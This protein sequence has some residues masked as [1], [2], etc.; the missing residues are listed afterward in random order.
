[1]A[2]NVE[3]P[4]NPFA[5]QPVEFHFPPGETFKHFEMKWIDFR[6]MSGV[7]VTDP[8]I[9]RRLQEMT[10]RLF[11]GLKGTGYG[12]CDIRMDADGE[13]YLL[14]INPN[15][16]MFY[17]P[18]D[19]GSADL[20][21]YYDPVGYR[22]SCRPSSPP[23]SSAKKNVAASGRAALS[24]QDTDPVRDSRHDNVSSGG[25]AGGPLCGDQYIG[26]RRHCQYDPFVHD[27]HTTIYSM[28]VDFILPWSTD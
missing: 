22:A 17:P 10:R 11:V 27:L 7:A 16:G 5:Y 6:N 4:M 3:D 28:G 13:L 14:E 2:E 12:R 23:R 8:D 9:S 21:L 24:W 20:C 25:S 26:H 1:M 15:C 19:P 18:E